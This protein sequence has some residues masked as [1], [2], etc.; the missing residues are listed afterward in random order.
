MK[1]LPKI[2]IADSISSKGIELLRADGLFEVI[3]KTGLQEPA[4]IEALEGCEALIVRSQTKVTAAVIEASP[5]LRI[6]GRAGV[7]IDN[8]HL[9]A[10]TA[11]GIVVMNAPGGNTISTAEH[12]LSLLLCTAR[13]IPQAHASMKIGKWD[14]KKFE[15]A[16]VHGKTLAILGMGRIGSEVAR[17]AVAF[18][19]RVL[20][21]DPYLSTSKARSLQI[22][23]VDQLHELLPR[24]DF[25]TV[26]MPLTE[27]TKHMIG[28]RELSFLKPG[29][30]LINCARGGLIDEEALVEGLSSGLI[31][32]A[33]LDV[34]EV[35]PLPQSSPLTQLENLILTPHLG[36]STIEAQEMVG[37]EIA[38]SV[39]LAL[40]KGEI[41]N[42]LNIPNIDEK[43][44]EIL[45]P[46]IELAGRLGQFLAH[47]GPK[48][49]E[50]ISICYSGR[51]A[52]HDMSTVSRSFLT[53][54]LEHIHGPEV[55]AV[56]VSSFLKQ[57]GLQVTESRKSEAGDFMDLLEISIEAGGEKSSIGAT[58]YGSKP[59][60]V[61]VNNRF[62]EG[63]PNGGL[64]LLENKDQPGI[65]G[66]LGSLFGKS[67]LNIANMSLSRNETL[68][69]ALILMN[70]DSLP[71]ATLLEQL[72]ADENILWVEV[73]HFL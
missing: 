56:N 62:V 48:R 34:F 68:G 50:K 73:I 33:A 40:L 24:A 72:R 71:P 5:S 28:R 55:N 20:V 66:D 32:G 1:P 47:L 23:V 9:E 49:T 52:E 4:L 7:G 42:A 26:H 12:A 59:R 45:G 35:E 53:G 41:R 18:G 65:V 19:M 8:V 58:F 14:R 69:T 25:I 63:H 3:V 15:G 60:I 57:A 21:Y 36:A 17:R 11:R 67:H 44:L 22:E 43:T 27:E 64:L 54:F 29:V 61:T 39:R 13:M 16:Q 38:E 30:R 51:I 46:W 6:I 70:L 37:I 2:F 10:A 31:A